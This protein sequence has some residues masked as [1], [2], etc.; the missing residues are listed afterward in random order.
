MR[1]SIVEKY[2]F[3]T[4]VRLHRETE[5]APYT[6]LKE[7]GTA[8]AIVKLSDDALSKGQVDPLISNLNHHIAEVVREKFAKVSEIDQVK[9][10]SVQAGREYV[11]AYVDYTHTLEAIHDVLD[12]SNHPHS[13]H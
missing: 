1:Y 12:H 13:G 6:G 5:G 3:E 9:D 11:A 2:F 8:K 10:Q 4:L 7:A